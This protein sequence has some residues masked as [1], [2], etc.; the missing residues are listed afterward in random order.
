MP[1]NERK[2]AG[3]LFSESRMRENFTY[4]IDEGTVET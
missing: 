1:A 3:G 4:G 2:F